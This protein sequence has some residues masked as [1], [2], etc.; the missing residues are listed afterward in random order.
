MQYLNSVAPDSAHRRQFLQLALLGMASAMLPG[1]KKGFAPDEE[2]PA[3]NLPYLDGT[4]LPYSATPG[5]P[6]VINFWATWCEPCRVEMPS[7]EK[8]S[9]LFRPEDLTVVGITVDSDV[10]LAREFSLVS[11]LTFP[12]LSDHVQTLS[13]GILRIPVF[14]STYLL[15]RDR[16]IAQVVHGARDW[17]DPKQVGEIER[18]LG[19]KR[20]AVT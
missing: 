7:L 8:L 16:T 1:C 3:L 5:I 6:Q 15:R 4:P 17:A 20:N 19:V 11:K 2:F 14:P 18:L 9:T 12:M 13:N 10:N